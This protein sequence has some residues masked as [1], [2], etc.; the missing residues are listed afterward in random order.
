[1]RSPDQRGRRLGLWFR[2]QLQRGPCHPGLGYAIR[3]ES[4]ILALAFADAGQ[5]ES[6]QIRHPRRK[7]RAAKKIGEK[8]PE[9][10]KNT[11]DFLQARQV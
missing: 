1:M 10:F 8:T 2:L 6:S 3:G 7:R 4:Q 9:I 5:R 11:I